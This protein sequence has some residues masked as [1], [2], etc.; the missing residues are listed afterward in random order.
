MKKLLIIIGFACL[1]NITYAQQQPSRKVPKEQVP[2]QQG[3]G[4]T[5]QEPVNRNE[6]RV[7]GNKRDNVIQMDTAQGGGSSQPFD[8]TPANRVKAATP[9]QSSADPSNPNAIIP[10]NKNVSADYNRGSNGGA[11]TDGLKVRTNATT[12]PASKK[13]KEKPKNLP[14]PAQ[15][16]TKT[17]ND[18]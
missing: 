7:I 6:D 16:N 10:E 17:R 11:G 1:A 14:G 4:K 3:G 15:K 13:P 12:K 5:G 9:D 8:K 2:G 18:Q